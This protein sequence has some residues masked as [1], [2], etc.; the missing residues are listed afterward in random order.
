MAKKKAKTL[1]CK[2]AKVVLRL[3]F[4]L[5]HT[6]FLKLVC[7]GETP[8]ARALIERVAPEWL[9]MAWAAGGVSLSAEPITTEEEGK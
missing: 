8:E 6:P 2:V 3:E 5:P 7:K 1:K 4:Q 9:K